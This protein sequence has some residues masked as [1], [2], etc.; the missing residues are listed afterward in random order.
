MKS[1]TK[2]KLVSKLSV[3]LISVLGFN[4][5]TN[6][7]RKKT[8]VLPFF[9]NYEVV[10]SETNGV[11][12]TDTIYP[13][14]P[15]FEF[16]NQDSVICKSQ[17]LKGK[18]W[19]V[20]FF[21]ASCPSICP[22]M[23]EQMKKVHTKTLDLASKV[24]FISFTIDP[25]NDTPSALKNYSKERGFESKN[26]TFLTGDEQKTHQLG[27]NNFMVHAARD[28]YEAGGFAHSDAIVLVDMEGHVRGVY[29]S[30]QHEL[31]DKLTLD[32]RKLLTQEYGF[33]NTK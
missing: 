15:A 10:T 21:F 8:P 1:K 28:A 14:I 25:N 7:E 24:Q 33:N 18:I 29:P 22:P 23:M 11:I 2:S 5:C 17:D 31:M 13:T 6:S 19:V 9:G 30:N 27:V 3:C 12:S 20:N 26:W 32:I 4:S 16:L